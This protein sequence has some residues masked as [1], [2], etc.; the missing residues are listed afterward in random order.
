MT[1]P[2][3][4]FL[5]SAAGYIIAAHR[6]RIRFMHLLSLLFDPYIATHL[7]EFYSL[8]RLETIFQ[9]ALKLYGKFRVAGEVFSLLDGIKDRLKWR[10]VYRDGKY[11]FDEAVE[12][13][14]VFEDEE[15]LA[16]EWQ[17]VGM[18]PKIEVEIGGL[19]SGIEDLD[20][21]LEYMNEARVMFRSP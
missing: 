21:P 5:H 15:N 12:S 1:A 9:Q 13:L 3:D 7:S 14:K 17:A 2:G 16:V 20:L 19:Y 4:T 18:R 6:M 11:R 8:E 10:R